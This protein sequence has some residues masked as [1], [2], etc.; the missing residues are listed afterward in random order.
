MIFLA[1]NFGWRLHQLDMKN[2]FEL[3]SYERS[4]FKFLFSYQIYFLDSRLID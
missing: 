1:I 2:V 4:T 3:G